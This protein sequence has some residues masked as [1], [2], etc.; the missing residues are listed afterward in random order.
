MPTVHRAEPVQVTRALVGESPLWDARES[1]LWW[2][3][4]PRGELHRFDP[5]SGRDTVQAFSGPLSAVALRARGGLLLALGDTVATFSPG[6]AD[7]RPRTLVRIPLPAAGH[8]LNDGRCDAWGRFW[9]GGM[10]T[11]GER[12]TSALHRLESDGT[13]AQVTTVLEGVSISN[14]LD[15]SPDGAVA[16]YA[17]SPTGEVTILDATDAGLRRVGTLA[18]FADCVPDGLTVDAGGGVWVAL[19]GGGAVHRYL[20]DGTLDAIVKVPAAKVTSCAFGGPDLRTLYI[21][22]ASRGLDAAELTGQPLAGALFACA[23][24][25]TGLPP[26]AFTG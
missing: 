24:G 22:T 5:V 16:Y 26:H 2:T 3:D 10:S 14:G 21:T 1:A 7:A 25:V 17:D 8:R 20:P 4:I 11:T 9:I 12:G 19:F 6:E 23:P 13:T 15:W 18:R